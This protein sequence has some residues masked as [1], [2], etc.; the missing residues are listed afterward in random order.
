MGVFEWFALAVLGL[1]ALMLI[2]VSGIDAAER[3]ARRKARHEARVQ[4]AV[5]ALGAQD[6][7]AYGEDEW[8]VVWQ[9]RYGG[10]E[11]NDAK[12]SNS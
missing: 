10:E 4:R 9:N 2:G 5:E 7:P 8:I 1:V 6:G 3:E 11:S 12:Q